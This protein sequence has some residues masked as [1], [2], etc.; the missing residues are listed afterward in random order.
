[1]KK[2]SLADKL[3]G[4]FS[5]KANIDAEIR[6]DLEQIHIEIVAAQNKRAAV[7]RAPLSVDEIEQRVDSLLANEE[8]AARN[9][10]SPGN[11]ATPG[12]HLDGCG[13]GAALHRRESN[14]GALCAIGFRSVIRAAMVAD[15][16]AEAAGVGKPLSSSERELETKRLTDE[17]ATLE[18]TREKIARQAEGS[19]IIVNRSEFADPRALLAVDSEL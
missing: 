4:L 6:A 18:L 9:F 10:Y 14:L 12:M 11:L 8:A 5:T 3:S 16:V 15:A 2:P 7:E 1:M 13:L 17:I 19:G